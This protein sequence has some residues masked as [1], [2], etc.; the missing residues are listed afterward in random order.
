DGYFIIPY[1]MGHYLATS[2]AA[3]KPVPAD[4]AEFKRCEAEVNGRIKRLLAVK[5]KHSAE[6]FWRQLGKVMWDYVGMA[7]GDASLKKAL[8]EIPAVRERF[9]GEVR[10]P[11]DDQ[12]LNQALEQA[13]RIAD[14]LEFAELLAHDALERDESCGAHF[15]VEHQY[16]DGEAKRDDERYQHVAAWE[17]AGP[18]QRPIRHVEPL[19]FESVKPSVRSYK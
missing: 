19:V 9:W 5:G 13:G 11:G 10:V 3:L 2:G 14:F 17:Y 8:G 1:T 7:R 15:R 18:D 4:H 12:D 6:M 16:P